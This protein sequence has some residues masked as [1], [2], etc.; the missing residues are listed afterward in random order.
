MNPAQVKERASS[1]SRE[2]V[3]LDLEKWS[4]LL[5]KIGSHD[6]E[7]YLLTTDELLLFRYP[8]PSEL[9]SSFRRVV[10]EL[11]PPNSEQLNTYNV[12]RC[13]LNT[14]ACPSFLVARASPSAIPRIVSIH[15]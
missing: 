13:E 11:V 12:H 15:I 2:D 14:P 5:S 9:E 8:R 4:C 1:T 6:V 3:D 10:E 7:D